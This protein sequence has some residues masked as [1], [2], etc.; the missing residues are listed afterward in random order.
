MADVWI[1]LSVCLY[2]SSIS[3]E[4]QLFA[5]F[6]FVHECSFIASMNLNFAINKKTFFF[7]QKRIIFKYIEEL[8]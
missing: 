4:K 3:R 7:L 2:V 6:F 8:S 1:C 5:L